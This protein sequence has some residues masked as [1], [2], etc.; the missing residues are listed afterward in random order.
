MWDKKS[1]E[2]IFKTLLFTTYIHMN[3]FL[4]FL[5]EILKS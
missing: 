1:L 5:Y 3:C 4:I 2:I